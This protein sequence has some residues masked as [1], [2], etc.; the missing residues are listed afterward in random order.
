[1]DPP[2][3]AEAA[4]VGRE[5]ELKALESALAAARGGRGR[6][7][8]VVGEPGIGKTRLIEEFVQRSGVPRDAVLWGR[9]PEQS[10]A[11]PYWP[12]TSVLR[13]LTA[14][15]DDAGLRELVG[16][17]A[18]VLAQLLPALRARLGDP[19]PL[20]SFD[21]DAARF[22][23]FDAVAGVLRRAAATEPVVVVVDDLHWADESSLLLQEFLVRE[24][25][26]CRVLLVGTC[27]DHPGRNARALGDVVRL[28]RRITLRGLDRAAVGAFVAAVAPALPARVVERLH[29]TSEGNPFFLAELLHEMQASDVPVLPDTVRDAVRRRL[30]G[31]SAT[32]RDTLATAAVIGRQFSSRLL[33]AATDV[34]AA[35]VLDALDAAVRA[36][37]V[38]AD[39][40][41]ERFRFSHALVRETLYGDLLPSERARRHGRVGAALETLH[42]HAPD[43]VLSELSLHFAQA[44]TAGDSAR[45]ARWAQAAARQATRQLAFEEAYLHCERADSALAL[46]GAAEADRL[47]VVLDLADAARAADRDVAAGDAFAR[48]ARMA[49]DA[50]DQRRFVRAALGY[51]LARGLFGG[52]DERAVDLLERALV[53]LGERDSP[54]RVAVMG[55][56]VESLYFSPAAARRDELSREALA[57]ARR[58]GD[59][60]SLSLALAARQLALLGLG[61]LDER[62]A[63]ADECIA[64]S[65]AGGFRGALHR[66]RICRVALLLECGD[67]AGAEEEIAALAENAQHTGRSYHRWQA[68]IP[69]ATVALLAGRLEEGARLAAE[70]STLRHGVRDEAVSHV[71]C[72]QTLL[73]RS[74]TGQGAGLEPSIRSLAERFPGIPTWKALLALVV[75]EGGRREEAFDLYSGLAAAG[76]DALPRD[77]L[78]VAAL[79]VLG[80]LAAV[81]E[82][83]RRAGQLHALLLP[84]AARNIV[85]APFVPGCLGPVT[86]YLALLAATLGRPD[87]AAVHF[88]AALAAEERL[89]ARVFLAHTQHEY[90]RFLQQR[91][92]PGDA[93]RARSLVA[94]ARATATALG[95]RPLEALLGDA[96]TEVAVEPPPA[97]APAAP[98]PAAAGDEDAVLR[99]EGD[100]WTVG[101]GGSAFRLKDA[102]GLGFL[103]TLL[104]HPGREFHVLELA[105]AG[106]GGG[107]A[108]P[109]G[110]QVGAAGDAGEM[111][112]PAARAAYRRRL[113]DLR[114]ECDEAEAFNDPGRAERARLEMEFLAAELS[115][116]VGLGGRSRRAASVAERVRQN[117]SRTI[118]AAV[119]RIGAVEPRLGEHLAAAVRT[120]VFCSYEPD[121]RVRVRWA[122]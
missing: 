19:G 52:V 48:A 98:P 10:G 88:E 21:P 62:R 37:V 7:V 102:K 66:G 25:G 63:L 65:I 97:A 101:W 82:D 118:G 61:D 67:V 108:V 35:D 95:L 85:V 18:A 72:L 92:G 79:A 47:G 93:D 106:P 104:A 71:F 46:L 74:E 109:E 99:R 53:L 32:G 26:T 87:E 89:G 11:P 94:A 112:D 54:G 69:R 103:A 122:L 58:L 51:A 84:F 111:L 81:F 43:A 24:L 14:S 96:G 55:T 57:S 120:G 12:W 39:G 56:L 113:A 4:F 77:S 13:Q 50:G 64:V 115:R 49:T 86:R 80:L 60:R 9:C 116:G 36:G 29:A 83:R 91:A 28:A 2:E 23:L 20:P 110:L 117:L 17:D 107:P 76:F 75:M 114:A 73:A 45:A 3:S 15:R 31:I 16:D 6:S 1:M 33:Q 100:F 30:D 27:R 105:G 90:A 38:G 42:A 78:F 59:P 68:A 119:R 70:A 22:R 8:V 34:P 41:P 5:T 121:P 40:P 44:A